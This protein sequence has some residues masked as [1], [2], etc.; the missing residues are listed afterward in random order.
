MLQSLPLELLT[1]V[2]SFCDSP[3][4]YSLALINHNFYDI[5]NPCLYRHNVLYDHPAAASVLWAAGAGSLNTLKIAIAHGANINTTGAYSE[6]TVWQTARDE[7]LSGKLYATPLH[8]AVDSGHE[9]VV[10]WLLENGARVNTPAFGLCVCNLPHDPSDIPRE[11][12]YPVHYAIFHNYNDSMLRLLLQ[13]R[14]VWSTIVYPVIADAIVDSNISAIDIIMQ[15][16]VFDPEYRDQFG[17]TAMHF[18][19]FCEDHDTVGE[20]TQKLV[21]RGVPLDA[22]S[23]HGTALTMM[24]R[25][26][27][28][29]HAIALLECGADPTA[30][31]E[32]ENGA[33]LGIIDR[34]FDDEEEDDIEIDIP[35]KSTHASEEHRQD[36][37]RLLE[38]VIAGGADVN[39]VIG[40]GN[41]PLTRPLYWALLESKDV[42]C[43]RILLDA[44]ARIEDA[45]VHS[46]SDSEGLL[47][48]FFNADTGFLSIREDDDTQKALEP[49]KE[50]LKLVLERGARIDAPENVGHSALDEV[51]G[52]EYYN[53]G[54]WKLKFL[55]E[56]ATSRNVR[57]E[58]VEDFMEEFREDNMEVYSLLKQLHEKLI[59][60]KNGRRY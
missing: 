39:R 21:D 52:V 50:S 25:D 14:A 20:I 9:D 26:H 47:R 30:D 5:F 38:L 53:G 32:E 57:V 33:G 8:L 42:E 49:Y 6:S 45:Y 1:Y 44:G 15:D 10:R 18:V 7:P 22:V 60:E 46:D 54:L 12:W 40:E 13:H 41:P 3:G 59:N 36:R 23:N 4:L 24:V 51:C 11:V 48:A 17:Y 56:H 16:D 19:S 35:G 37:R 34:I 27:K 58:F 31:P 43:V 2:G 29:K 55:V 28:F